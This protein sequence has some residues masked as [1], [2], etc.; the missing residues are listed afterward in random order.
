MANRSNASTH[1]KVL[2]HLIIQR[3]RRAR[4]LV[5]LVP[6]TR[7]KSDLDESASSEDEFQYYTRPTHSD[8]ISPPPSL[9]YSIENL[10]LL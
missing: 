4:Q 3:Q 9:P 2:S 10:N 5:A 8:C 1:R 6:K 7:A